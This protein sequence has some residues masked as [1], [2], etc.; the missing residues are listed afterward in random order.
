MHR[1]EGHAIVIEPVAKTA[2]VYRLSDIL[3]PAHLSFD[4][5]AWSH[6]SCD[7]YLPSSSC[8]K[9]GFTTSRT[10][11]FNCLDSLFFVFG[12]VGHIERP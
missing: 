1:N 6:G 8:I 12:K 3:G 7:M 2:V 10:V 9:S 4:L 5:F 11:F